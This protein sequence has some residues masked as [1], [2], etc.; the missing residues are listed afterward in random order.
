M[1]DSVNLARADLTNESGALGE[2]ASLSPRGFAAEPPPPPSF[3]PDPCSRRRRGRCGSAAPRC[4]GC[5]RRRRRGGGG[6]RRSAGAR[7]T[8]RRPRPART[9]A[10]RRCGGDGSILAVLTAALALHGN[11]L[12]HI[13][14]ERSRVEQDGHRHGRLRDEIYVTLAGA[15][16]ASATRSGHGSAGSP[17]RSAGS[18]GQC[19]E[20]R[21]RSRLSRCSTQLPWS[22]GSA[23]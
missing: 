23:K 2:T 3:P 7:R 1:G 19:P 6:P 13:S 18:G 4:V 14:G 20:A 22:W 5:R 21:G 16:G 9:R 11:C 8:P 17:R 12:D 15:D 10:A